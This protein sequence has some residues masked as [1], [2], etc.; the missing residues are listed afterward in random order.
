MVVWRGSLSRCG[1]TVCQHIV[2]WI[3]LRHR[4]TPVKIGLKDIVRI[5]T[6]P[7]RDYGHYGIDLIDVELRELDSGCYLGVEDGCYTDIFHLPYFFIHFVRR[8][9]RPTILS[10]MR[11]T[12]IPFDAALEGLRTKMALYDKFEALPDERCLRLDYDRDILDLES[13]IRKL[14]GFVGLPITNNEVSEASELF[15][16]NS[17][18]HRF[19]KEHKR[20]FRI[21]SAFEVAQD[22]TE[23]GIRHDH[24]ILSIDHGGLCSTYHLPYEV[25]SDESLGRV[26][27]GEL[28]FRLT[29]N[30]EGS[31]Y[32]LITNQDPQR[33]T[34]RVSFGVKIGSQTIGFQQHHISSEDHSDWR[35]LLTNE[36]LVR[37]NSVAMPFLDKYGYPV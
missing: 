26:Q 2:E 16:R 9:L 6:K 25:F 32:N 35:E 37:L 20:V 12:S 36:Q 33:K 14:S 23:P 1:G 28:P 8:D 13:G 5:L 34:F 29:V 21:L 11:L 31:S 18:K 4:I 3:F 27:Q 22:Y 15:S 17:L 19:G 30:L 7:V 24:V 10:H